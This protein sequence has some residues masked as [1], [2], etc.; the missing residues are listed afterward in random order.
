MLHDNMTG[1]KVFLLFNAYHLAQNR[2]IERE[3][4]NALVQ[5]AVH[6]CE[7]LRPPKEPLAAF[8]TSLAGCSASPFT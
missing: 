2:G 6:L 7:K 5:S 1:E 3:M 8:L 4:T